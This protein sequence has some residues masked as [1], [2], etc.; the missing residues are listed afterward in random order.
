[1]APSSDN[2]IPLRPEQDSAEG[3][4]PVS[5]R[6][7]AETVDVVG[8]C[9]VHI[10]SAAGSERSS[11]TQILLHMSAV[12]R[13]LED[14]AAVTVVTW[15]DVSWALRFCSARARALTTISQSAASLGSVRS[16]VWPT[17]TFAHSGPLSSAL[18]EVRDLIVQR[19]PQTRQAC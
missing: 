2:V 13:R 6:E 17:G 5:L 18:R 14:L 10:A 15:P 11:D 4:L 16:D 8:H 12:E 9:L 1:M 7:L 19:Y 3:D